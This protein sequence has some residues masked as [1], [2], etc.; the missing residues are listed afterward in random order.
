[1]N[2]TTTTGDTFDIFDV[3][4]YLDPNMTGVAPEFQA[5]SVEEDLQ[6][7]LRYWFPAY[8]FDGVVNTATQAIAFA[9]PYVPMR[10]NPGATMSLVGGALRGYDGS[11]APNVTSLTAYN[12][13]TENAGI[14][15]GMSAGG[16]T[17]GRPFKTL[18][19]GTLTNYIAMSARM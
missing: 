5:P 10:V 3:G 11:N 9:S 13:N 4:W 19:D 18:V 15:F 7:C 16:L 8:R 12:F 6:D 1:M 14:T 2:A 17:P